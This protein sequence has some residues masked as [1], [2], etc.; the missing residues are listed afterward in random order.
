MTLGAAHGDTHFQSEYLRGRHVD[1]F[2]IK[3]RLF[4]KGVS[5]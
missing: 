1:L 2:Y 4:Y 5:G 3:A